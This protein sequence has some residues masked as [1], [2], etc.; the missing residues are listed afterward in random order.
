MRHRFHRIPNASSLLRRGVLAT[1]IGLGGLLGA[2]AHAAVPAP[3]A[4]LA[5][6]LE[7]IINLNTAT[8]EQLQLL[9][10]VGPATAGKIIAYRD[11]HAF[12]SI[13]QLM[14]IKGIGRKRFDAVKDYLAVDGETTLSVATT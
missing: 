2:P 3:L 7:G 8:S 5:P 10:G 13:R 9:P 6:T 4:M 11:R 12:T 14:R 1:L